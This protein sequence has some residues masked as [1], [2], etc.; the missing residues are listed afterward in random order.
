MEHDLQGKV[1]IVTGSNSG[2]GQ[3]IA[4]AFAANGADVAVTWFE[5]EGSAQDT[6][7]AVESA[8]GRALVVQVDVR[9]PAA[10]AQ[11]FEETEAQLGTPYILV[12]DAGVDAVISNRP[13]DVL[14][15][16]AR[17]GV[18]IPSRSR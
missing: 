15:A 2:I 18:T 11:L 13:G 3:A 12:N 17:R 6:R 16:L 1:A 4:K 14:D 5:D 9:D 8:G 10:V 7:K